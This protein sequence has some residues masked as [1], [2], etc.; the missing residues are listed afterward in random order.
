MKQIASRTSPGILAGIVLL[1]DGVENSDTAPAYLPPVPVYSIGVG[2]TDPPP[3]IDREVQKPVVP[4]RVTVNSRVEVSVTLR[5]LGT[6]PMSIPLTLTLSNEDGSNEKTVASATLTFTQSG[7]SRLS[8]MGFVPSAT[9]RFRLT[10]SAPARDEEPL[11][12]NNSR[13]VYIDVTDPDIPVLYLEGKPRFEFKFFKRALESDEFVQPTSIMKI[14][15]NRFLA[16]VGSQSASEETSKLPTDLSAFKVIVLGDIAPSVL[17]ETWLRELVTYVEKGGG[18]LFLGSQ[19][20]FGPAGASSP[21]TPLLPY[22]T[23]D[24]PVRFHPGNFTLETSR[25]GRIHS[26]FG[27]S[28]QR[29]DPPVASGAFSFPVLKSGAS[30]LAYLKRDS[31]RTPG[32]LVQRYGGGRVALTAMAAAWPWELRKGAMGDRTT[33]FSQF[34][35]QTV[36]WLAGLE[37]EEA[38]QEAPIA[39]R[40]DCHD[41][42]AGEPVRLTAFVSRDAFDRPPALTARFETTNGER[43]SFTLDRTATGNSYRY[44]TEYRS[45]QTGDFN[46]RVRAHETNP[47]DGAEAESMEETV[48]FTVKRSAREW[49]RCGLNESFLKNLSR[50]T[51]GRY[52]PLERARDIQAALPTQRSTRTRFVE[53]EIWNTPWLLALLSLLLS[54]EWA[55]RRRYE[56]LKPEDL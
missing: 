16:Q 13:A 47:K 24:A 1:S 10:A 51:G 9:G 20:I 26:L 43:F 46:L 41:Y 7:E 50:R 49:E 23:K 15:P 52:F 29:F 44:T 18:L 56:R 4:D 11:K 17:G 14:G 2:S 5:C 34:W 39:V 42:Y 6:E 45:D 30:V 36:R 53:R 21:L 8:A 25:Q 32:V 3:I 40:T 54:A 35:R 22:E 37:E 38:D 27:E 33:Y 28:L 48:A 55:I 31:F 19:G 12:D